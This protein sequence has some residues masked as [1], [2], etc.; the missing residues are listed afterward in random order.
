MIAKLC[1]FLIYTYRYCISPFKR[2]S[3]CFEP[4]CS[5]YAIHAI[6]H[7]GVLKG[8]YL[9]FRRLLKCHPYASNEPYDPVPPAPQKR[10]KHP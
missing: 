10:M 7:H 6:E 2:P 9:A 8:I 5:L 4:S 3:C 1:L